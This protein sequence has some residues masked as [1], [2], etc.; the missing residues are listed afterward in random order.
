MNCED[1]PHVWYWVPDMKHKCT[2]EGETIDLPDFPV[3]L[4]T[5]PRKV[6]L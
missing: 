3:I 4:D 2:C 5:C 1:C 6:G